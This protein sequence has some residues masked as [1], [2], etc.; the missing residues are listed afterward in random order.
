MYEEY[1]KI[2]IGNWHSDIICYPS[3]LPHEKYIANGGYDGIIKILDVNSGEMVGS[4]IGFKDG[5]NWISYTKEGY[6]DC[7][8]DGDEKFPF[9]KGMTVFSSTEY[10]KFFYNPE[11]KK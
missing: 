9:V 5:K 10:K 1:K 6:Y 2:V 4:L 11:F 3:F 7:S 8:E